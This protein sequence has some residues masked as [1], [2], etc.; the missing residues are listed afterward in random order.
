M[1]RYQTILVG[2]ALDERDET[3]LRHAAR[4]AHA[5]QA[6]HVYVAHIAASLDLPKELQSQTLESFLPRDEQLEQKLQELMQKHRS[7]F[8]ADTDFHS[9]VREGKDPIELIRVVS[10]KSADLFCLG[11][12]PPPKHDV[13]S[14]TALKLLRKSPCSVF[15]V[16]PGASTDYQQILVPVD[17]SDYSRE[18]LEVAIALARS[19]PGSALTIVHVYEVPLGWHKTGRSYE[20]FAAI[21]RDQAEENWNRFRAQIDF[22][23]VPWTIRYELS[24]DVTSKILE[25]ADAIHASLIVMGSHGRTA[26]AMFLLGH[27]ADMVCSHT[28]RP[29]LCVKRKGEI[30]NFLHALLQFYGFEGS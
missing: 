9:V 5:A 15:V 12:Q 20:E 26:P 24:D 7:L 16:T 25:V 6:R 29:V 21:M 2:A 27:V 17:F 8:P 18:A 22:H 13:L 23:D 1:R 10:Q 19:Q 4:F 11:T 28:T 3:T 14:R 30:V